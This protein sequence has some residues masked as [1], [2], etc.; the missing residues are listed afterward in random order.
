MADEGPVIKFSTWVDRY[1]AIVLAVVAWSGVLL[2]LVLSLQLANANGHSMGWG[3]AIYLG[4]FTVLTNGFVAL[5]AN[6]RIAERPS[7]RGRWLA[8]DSVAGC[9]TTAIILVGI[10]YH[11]LLRQIWSPQG[12]QWVADVILHYVVPIMT[13]TWWLL[14]R[15]PQPMSATLP[16]VWCIYPAAYLVYALLRGAWIGSYPYPFIDVTV[17]GFGRV[18]LNSLGL[19]VVFIGLGYVVRR[20]ATW[21]FQR[22][23]SRTA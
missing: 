19:L 14:I 21:R 10:A 16:L 18:V 6:A 1:G 20:A 22:G 3:L 5:V 8:R 7:P 15:H 11:L 4:Y 12:L 2:Q 17:L 23:S 9:A 13:L